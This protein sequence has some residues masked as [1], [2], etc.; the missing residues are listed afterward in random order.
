MP[1]SEEN[2]TPEP[3]A[4][5]PTIRPEE[6]PPIDWNFHRNHDP[7]DLIRYRDNWVAWS[8]DGR[9]VLFAS[10]DPY[11]LCEMIDAAGLTPGHYVLDGIPSG[12]GIPDFGWVA[13]D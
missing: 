3:P 4:P 1:P 10:P 6:F 7:E 2:G 5:A 13:L 12:D 9:K 11:K 8:L